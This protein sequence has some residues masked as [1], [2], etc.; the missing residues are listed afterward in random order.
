VTTSIVVAFVGFG[1]LASR[2]AKELAVRPDVVVRAFLPA[3]SGSRG[4]GVAGRRA[5]FAGVE[6]SDRLEP[7][8]A[9]A[10]VVVASVPSAASAAVA[11]AC[12]PLLERDAV[13]VDPSS[14]APEVKAENAALVAAAGGLF[15]DAAV[16][17]TAA[18]SGLAVP[19][20]ASGSGVQRF[21]EIADRLGM[22]VTPAGTVAGDA[23]RAKLIR[24][25]YMKG[26]DALLVEMLTAAEAAG[27]TSLVVASIAR[28]PGEQV[29]FDQLVER[30]L[31]ALTL[32]VARRADELRDA[33]AVLEQ[34]GVSP[35][36]TTAA[37][38]RL[39]R[40]AAVEDV[41]QMAEADPPPSAQDVSAALARAAGSGRSERLAAADG[42]PA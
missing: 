27:I 5:R 22:D 36:L 3:G 40:M 28:A 18:L 7:V 23:A 37:A 2:W 29:T 17:G 6:P 21:A 32:H 1:D 38:E 19:L 11:A 8:L 30:V 35:E 12:A 31:P 20:L 34:L 13:Y 42:E 14:S 24:S 4:S 26:R 25:V 10:H 16:L 33:A 41:R 39:R 9:G 15:V